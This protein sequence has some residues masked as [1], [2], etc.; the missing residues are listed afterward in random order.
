S[1]KIGVYFDLANALDDKLRLCFHEAIIV[2]RAF[3]CGVHQC[4][5]HKSSCL[6]IASIAALPALY[7]S[8]CV[9]PL[10]RTRPA[11]IEKELESKSHRWQRLN[12]LI[13]SNS[14]HPSQSPNRVGSNI[15]ILP[16][17]R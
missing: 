12:S 7:A 1:R 5:F 2:G 9:P 4:Y 13:L 14:K 15:S 11:A 17:A 3:N 10:K 16:D 8:S 6:I